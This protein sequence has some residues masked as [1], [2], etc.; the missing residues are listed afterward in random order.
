QTQAGAVLEL[1]AAELYELVEDPLLI[2]GRD[3]LPLIRHC[4]RDT[5]ILARFERDSD[6]SS[7]PELDRVRKQVEQDL[8]NATRI[9][10]DAR[11]LFSR[12]PQR[13]GRPIFVG[14]WPHSDEEIFNQHRELDWLKTQVDLPCFDLGK[15]ENVIHEL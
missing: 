13:Q 3:A 10:D 9:R 1:R 2:V 12:A 7:A 8:P 5:P 6:G 14:K 15:V 4:D 11:T